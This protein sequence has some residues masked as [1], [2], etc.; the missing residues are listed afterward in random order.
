MKAQAGV[1]TKQNFFGTRNPP[2]PTF[3]VTTRNPLEPIFSKLEWVPP[4]TPEPMGSWV[5]HMPTPG[6]KAKKQKMFLPTL[7]LVEPRD[8]GG[9]SKIFLL[10][11]N[12]LNLKN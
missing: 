7:A 9:L 11:S 6:L 8:V 1:G 12:K 10:I 4:G 2:E 5:P 3:W